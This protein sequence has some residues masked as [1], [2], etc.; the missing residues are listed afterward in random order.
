MVDDLPAIETPNE[1]EK[2]SRKEYNKMIE[3]MVQRIQ[4]SNRVERDGN[5]TRITGGT[6]IVR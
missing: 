3:D 5:S 6:I 4:N 2:V 1:G